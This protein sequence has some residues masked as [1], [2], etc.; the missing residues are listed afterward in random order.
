MCSSDVEQ[1]ISLMYFFFFAPF[2]QS[3]VH[4]VPTPEF[5]LFIIL[6]LFLLFIV[7][8]LQESCK[9]Y[10]F[11]CGKAFVIRTNLVSEMPTLGQVFLSLRERAPIC[12]GRAT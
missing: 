8:R 10:K 3:A 1:D 7:T 4:S 12:I 5:G 11:Y 6:F 2:Q 9:S